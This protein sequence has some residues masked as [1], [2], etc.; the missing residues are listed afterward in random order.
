MHVCTCR[1]LRCFGCPTSA[2]PAPRLNPYYKFLRPTCNAVTV[3]LVFLQQI[4]Q[5]ILEI[6]FLREPI[7]LASGRQCRRLQRSPDAARA[8]QKIAATPCCEC[9]MESWLAGQLVVVRVLSS[10]CKWR[11]SQRGPAYFLKLICKIQ[12]QIF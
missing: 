1:A 10:F 11:K 4:L 5:E 7:W 8:L 12:I 6:C 2:T 3:A 9:G